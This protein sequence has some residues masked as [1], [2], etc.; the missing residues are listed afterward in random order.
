MGYL[1][2]IDKAYAEHERM[3]N[4]YSGVDAAQQHAAH[5]LCKDW[6][7]KGM[8][9]LHPCQE[10]PLEQHLP[11]Q[12]ILHHHQKQSQLTHGLQPLVTQNQLG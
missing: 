1:Q 3:A 6:W 10:A 12:H 9:I 8:R 11:Q 4:F 5:R 2:D 7:K